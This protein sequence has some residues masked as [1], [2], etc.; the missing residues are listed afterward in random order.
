MCATGVVV[1]MPCSYEERIH[2]LL[3]PYLTVD[4][5]VEINKIFL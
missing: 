5:A 1:G 4:L 3:R 2:L